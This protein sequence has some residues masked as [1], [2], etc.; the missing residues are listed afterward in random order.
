M[1]NLIKYAENKKEEAKEAGDADDGNEQFF[2][3]EF[4]F[5][6]NSVKDEFKERIILGELEEESAKDVAL[7]IRNKGLSSLFDEIA[8]LMKK[9]MLTPQEIRKISELSSQYE[10]SE[11]YIAM[12]AAHLAAKEKFSVQILVSRAM[13]IF[14][15]GITSAEILGAYL[16]EQEKERKDLI[17]YKKIFG[18]INRKPSKKENDYL[19][20][21]SV[22]YGFGVPIVA[23]AY[24]FSSIKTSN[25]SFVYM[26][27]ILTDW[28]EHSCKTVE[29]C[30]ARYNERGEELKRNAEEKREAE[31]RR[32]P[33]RK[34]EKPKKRYG[35]FDAEEAFKLAL[36]RSFTSDGE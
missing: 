32:R 29:E 24:S 12:L 10:L 18:I 28:H 26:D 14:G 13:N 36:D 19:H 35:E 5:Y 31:E 33:S 6:G 30:R 17:E 3:E 21:W 34:A 22:E 8:K 11:E 15:Q 7:T 4:S 1:N 23:E 27:K 9:P 16:S 2:N 20:K 25:V